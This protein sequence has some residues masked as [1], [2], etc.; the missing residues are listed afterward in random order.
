MITTTFTG[1]LGK[2]AEI[3]EVGITKVINFTVAVDTGY[4]DKKKTL[5]IECGKFGDNV[6]VAEYL[7]KGQ[8]VLIIGEPDIRTWDSNGKHGASLNVRVDKIELLGGKQEGQPTQHAQIGGS[9]NIVEDDDL[10]Y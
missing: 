2:P 10:P 9:S 3:R 6:K 1:R 4:G 8:Q 5:W 7:Q